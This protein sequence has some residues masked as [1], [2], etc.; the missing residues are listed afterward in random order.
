MSEHEPSQRLDT[1]V[2]EMAWHAIG[3]CDGDKSFGEMAQSLEAAARQ[4]RKYEKAGFALTKPVA[5]D[6]AQ[7]Q[8]ADPALAE[9]YRAVYREAID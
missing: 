4:L 5:A 7:F 6:C 9:R 2:F 3:I 1:E 8:L